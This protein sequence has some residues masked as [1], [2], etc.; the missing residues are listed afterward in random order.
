MPELSLAEIATAVSGTVERACGQQTFKDF[1]FDTRAMKS[2]SLFF[3]LSSPRGDGHDHV[4]ELASVPGSAAVVRRGFDAGRSRLPLLRVNDPLRAAQDLAVYVR[5]KHRAV[6]YVGITGSAGKTTTKEFLF[7]ILSHKFRSFRSPQNWNNW[8]GLPFS[9]LRMSGREQA[10]VFELAMSDPGIGEIDRLAVI[11]KPDIAVLLNVFPVHLEFLGTVANAARAKAE[12]LGHLDA[13][14]C[15]FVNGDLPLLRRAVSGCKGQRIFFGRRPGGNQI[16]LKNVTREKGG[17]RL[18]IDFFDIKEEF[19]APLVSHTHIENLFAAI[20]VAQRLGMKDFEIQEAVARLD[21]VIGRGQVRRQGRFTIID[22]TYNSNPEAL[23]RTLQWVDGEYRQKKAAVLGDMLELGRNEIAYHR[24]AGRLFARL[25]FEL[26]LTVGVRAEALANAARRA[27][28]PAR[29]LHCFATAAEAGASCAGNCIHGKK[30]RSCSR[31]RGAW[32]WKGP[33]RSS[34]MAK[35]TVAVLGFGKT[36][37]AVLEFLLEREPGTPL[38]LFNDSEIA[39]QE[40]YHEFARRGV[41]FLIGGDRFAELRT[42]GRV[43]M[44]P[45]FDGKSQRFDALRRA[46]AEVIS[47]IEFAFR[48]LQ[49]RVI[50]VSGSNGKSTT[51]SLV[52]H[53]LAGA[54]FKSRL[55]G[56]IGIPLIAEVNTIESGSLVVLELSS[57]QLEEIVRFRPEVA[58]LLNITPDHLDRYPS[59]AE[60]AAAKF[61]LFKNQQPGDWMVLNADDPLLADAGKLGCGR[62]LWFSSTRPAAGHD[63]GAGMENGNIVLQLGE[64]SERISLRR[65]PL[66]GIHNLENIMAAALACRIV[67]MDAAAIEAGLASFRGLPHRM[68]AAG[69]IEGVVF[70]NDSKATNIDAALKSIASIDGELVVILGGKDKG[71][72]FTALLELLRQRARKIL[73]LGQA[74]PVIA[75]QLRGLGERLAMVGD[76]GEAV[77]RGRELLRH[78]GGTVL[79]APACASF[80]MFDN[81]EHRGDVFKQEVLRLRQREGGNG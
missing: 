9:L 66:R 32:S 36:G 11:L 59:M 4:R 64:G 1:R 51:V 40:R 68:E 80:D 14:G 27:G 69:S 58:V 35:R 6:K 2:G 15:A 3:A 29:R 19:F 28:Y 50:A 55:A 22:E 31:G 16:V 70:I 43:I 54:G 67:G 81:F 8:I 62:P 63:C 42:C 72:D 56:N 10:A 77:T 37:Q 65:N 39:D 79:L 45:G 33:S 60:Y 24:E 13:D 48:Q 49:A 75:D 7:Q 12:I 78:C 47:E 53:L 57:F 73:L 44:S 21:P 71:G 30:G 25:H 61:N 23:K 26:L 46:G 20:L 41:R 52:Q 17:S 74:A 34:P 5:R 38:V 18:H 76:L